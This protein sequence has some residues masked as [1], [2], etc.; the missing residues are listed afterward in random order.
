MTKK[1][2]AEPALSCHY[3]RDRFKISLYKKCE[4]RR[5]HARTLGGLKTCATRTLTICL[6]L[7][8]NIQAQKKRKESKSIDKSKVE[9]SEW[10]KA[11]ETLALGPHPQSKLTCEFKSNLE[12]TLKVC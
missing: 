10:I 11:K 12:A 9:I 6:T 8:K 4:K 3:I 5:T 7:C 2:V 1:S